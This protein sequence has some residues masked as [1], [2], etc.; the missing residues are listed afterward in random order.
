[1]NKGMHIHKYAKN[2]NSTKFLRSVNSET[3][4]TYADAD[5]E[6]AEKEMKRRNKNRK[7]A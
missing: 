6:G 1:M 4:K 5:V 2:F 7:A 3:L